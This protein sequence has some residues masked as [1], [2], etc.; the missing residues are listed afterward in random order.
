MVIGQKKNMQPITMN[1]GIL[2]IPLHLFLHFFFVVEWQT[3]TKLLV[4]SL[5]QNHFTHWGQSVV[6]LIVFSVMASTPCSIKHRLSVS[7]V[8]HSTSL[9][10]GLYNA[11]LL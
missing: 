6:R 4:E 3:G 2:L 8:F 10:T 1:T 9:A 7:V 11:L 5:D